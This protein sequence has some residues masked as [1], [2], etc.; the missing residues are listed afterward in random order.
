MVDLLD[1]LMQT[2]DA[3]C[4]ANLPVRVLADWFFSDCAARNL[5]VRTIDFYRLKLSYLI[6]A[7]G[8][9][10][11]T[12]ITTAQMKMLITHYREKRE[13]SVGTANHAITAW[14][15][16]FHYLYQE[17][18][19]D[20]DP[21]KRLKKLKGDQLI[22]APLT[23]KEIHI[24]LADAGEGFVGIRNTAM[25]LVLLDCGLRLSELTGLKLEDIDFTTCQL[26]VFGKGRKERL[27]PF[28][29]PVRRML[30]K[31]LSHRTTRTH[32]KALW[33]DE[34]G[35]PFTDEGFRSF[36]AR[37]EKRTGIRVHAHKFRHT[38]ASQYIA[39]GG[40]PAYLQRLLGH[41]TPIMTNRY[42]HLMDTDA[43]DDHR[44]ASPV[45]H[46]LGPRWRGRREK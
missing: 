27:V 6:E 33:I 30:L 36:L 4:P 22:P 46:L 1:T 9:R 21:A 19:I 15:V 3:S 32:E 11:P 26:L 45:T 28:S 37:L 8:E 25:L 17:E 20:S 29:G 35:V 34:E 13:W 7:A 31:Y 39:D 43:R 40:N 18:I 42:V 16:F 24:L 2:Q 41:T 44:A 14:K 5:Q 23:P 38:F 12:A 10:P